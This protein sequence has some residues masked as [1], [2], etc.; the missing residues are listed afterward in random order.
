MDYQ[1]P[2]LFE[3]KYI[4]LKDT[5]N[6]LG[7]SNASVYNWIR[8]GYLNPVKDKKLYQKKEVI[9]LKKRIEAGELNRLN[10]YANKSK[11]RKSFIPLE[12]L[13]SGMDIKDI[14]R[15][16][17]YA[18]HNK[19]DI[20]SS[21]FYLCLNVLKY[22]KIIGFESIDNFIKS[23]FKIKNREPLSKEL[24]NW[25]KST[26]NPSEKYFKLL[27]FQLPEYPDTPGIIYQ[28]LKIEGNKNKQGSY[29]TPDEFIDS[30]SKE[31]SYRNCVFLDP[32]CGTGRFLLSF[33]DKIDNPDNLFG[34][35]I[36]IIAV[37]IARINIILKYKD[38]NFSPNIICI[39]TLIPGELPASLKNEEPR[40]RAPKGHKT[41]GYLRSERLRQAALV[42]SLHPH[43]RTE[44]YFGCQNK[45]FNVIASN[46][47][48]GLHFNKNELKELRTLYPG[49]KSDE[50]FS[51]FLRVAIDLLDINGSLI[52]ILPESILNI[53]IHSDIREYILSNLNIKKIK[54]LNQKFR[55]VFTPVI[56][57]ELCR[58]SEHETIIEF[59]NKSYKINPDRFKKNNE[60]IFDIHINS[61]DSKILKAIYEHHHISLKNNADWALGIVTG[62]NKKFLLEKNNKNEPIFRGRDI[63]PFILSYP[64]CFINFK[65]ELYQ[66]T[67]PENKYRAPE[68][69]I[70]KFISNKLIFAYD[71]NKSLTLNSANILI[72]KIPEYS[73]KII[74]ALFNSSLYQFIF[75]K[76]FSAIKVLKS[77]LEDLPIPILGIENKNKIIELVNI[78]L[79]RKNNHKGIK[80]LDNFIF[81]IFNI[82]E[83]EYILDSIS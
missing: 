12:L 47:P 21:L 81:D 67:A 45:K 34:F 7:I 43:S 71:T 73:I 78:I 33:A 63:K 62:N 25:Y 8:H 53:K 76:K 41:P 52:F 16:I 11:S 79:S 9:S 31:Y 42:H 5:A 58:Q 55:N 30:I 1:Q 38:C 18:R 83:K 23:N 28:S 44:R 72:P 22:N 3:N 59:K 4:S 54:Y 2:E 75:Q 49:I 60:K 46:P 13:D 37:R 39:N 20:N 77:H 26:V 80:N 10:R 82:K 56:I 24:L 29:Y 65:P 51:Y 40:N 69:L 36:D 50:S 19:L 68:K 57:M 27:Q 35:D 15:I 74:M 66:Q 14:K 32:C 48:W 64:Q 70:Y 6:I 17:D 61:I